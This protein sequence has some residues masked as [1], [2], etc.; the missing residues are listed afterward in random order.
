ALE[1]RGAAGSKLAAMLSIKEYSAETAPGM[2]DRFFQLPFEFVITQSFLFSHRHEALTKIQRQQRLLSQ[3]EDLA[4]SQVQELSQALDEATSGAI[5]FGE[6]HLTVM[7]L[8][9]TLGKLNEAVAAIESE[10]LDLGILAVREDLNLEPCFWA[11][12]PGN[13]EHITRKAT[14][15]TANL[16]GFVSLHNFPSGRIKGNH[17]GPAVTV[18]ETQSGTPYYFNFHAGDVGH[19]SVIGPT[20][21]GKTV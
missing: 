4:V 15:S 3:S 2:L 9:A 17:W 18:L 7:P 21:S 14:L 12:L 6:H 1:S 11:Q 8:A 16:S 20:G 13:A 5:A 10:L 19:T